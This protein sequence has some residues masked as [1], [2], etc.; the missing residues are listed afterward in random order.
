MKLFVFAAMAAIGMYGQ[1]PQERPLTKEE[2]L[3]FRATVAEINE[4]R[5]AYKIAEFNEKV[6]PKVAEQQKAFFA[7]CE[8][9]GVPKDKINPQSGPSECS[10]NTGMDDSGNPIKDAKGNTVQAKVWWNKAPAKE[11]PPKTK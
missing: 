7:A 11:E 9:V 5:A 8:S 3:T 6:A 1:T 2:L 4:L 10:L